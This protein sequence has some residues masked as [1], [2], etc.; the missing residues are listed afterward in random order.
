[1]KN[2]RQTF[3]TR[4]DRW[5]HVVLTAALAAGLGA[6]S[7]GC[8]GYRLGSTLPP[9]VASVYVPTAVNGTDEPQLETAVTRAVIR[10]F[11]RD[12]TLKIAAAGEADSQLD[13]TL[14]RFDL[15]PV[16]YE[17]DQV[18][19]TREY[20]MRIT[21]D[22]VFTRPDSGET[23]LNR[24]VQGDTTFDFFGDLA[25]SKVQ[26]LPQAADDLAHDIVETMVEYW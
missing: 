22:I 12:G 17:R 9:G 2:S 21:A 8:V 5:M 11:Q 14:V 26:A 19:T 4:R 15:E 13:I 16:R 18:R 3:R 7:N 20:R 6:A 10:E 23:L 1:M 25:S 24:R